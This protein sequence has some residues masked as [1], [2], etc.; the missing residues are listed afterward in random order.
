MTPSNSS[1]YVDPVRFRAACQKA[2]G[3]SA[4]GL[5]QTFLDVAARY[6]MYPFLL[7]ALGQQ[8]SRCGDALD[9]NGT[10][11]GGHGHG[12][13]QIDDGT[14]APWLA[15]NDW[16]NPVVNITKGAD[17]WV[18]YYGN[19]SSK[20]SLGADCNGTTVKVDPPDPSKPGKG[21]AASHGGRY[22]TFPDPRP[23]SG[24]MLMWATTAAY[25]TGPQNVV[26][27]V[28]LGLP[29]GYTT[30]KNSIVQGGAMM[31]YN[32]SV[33]ARMGQLFTAYNNS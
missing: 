19:L 31:D 32:D 24:D 21:W 23:F 28:A 9:A 3:S 17:I 6:Q 26:V 22:G 16:R 8:E 11:D 29:V 4:A 15:S 30:T 1:N 10:G 18:G 13:M 14:W 27:S 7:A 2:Y 12:I 33:Q 25:N 20:V 5:A